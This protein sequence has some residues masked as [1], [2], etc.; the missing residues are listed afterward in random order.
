VLIIP[1]PVWAVGFALEQPLHDATFACSA[2]GISKQLKYKRLLCPL[3]HLKTLSKLFYFII[4][5]CFWFIPI[6]I[7]FGVCTFSVWVCIIFGTND[8]EL[9]SRAVLIRQI[10]FRDFQQFSPEMLVRMTN[11]V[12][13][14]FGLDSEERIRFEFSP[15][16]KRI[17]LSCQN[18][19]L[20]LPPLPMDR[21]SQ[22]ERNLRIIAKARYNQWIK[23]E[24]NANTKEREKI[25]K[26]ILLEL[27]YWDGVYRE[28]L[29]AIGL[30]QPTIQET[31]I[32]TDYLVNEFKEG[33]S[34]EQIAQIENF[35]RKIIGAF[36]QHE[37]KKTIDKATN[38]LELFFKPTPQIK[39]NNTKKKIKEGMLYRGGV[40]WRL[41]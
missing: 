33:E 15:I 13:L 8:P 41:I 24:A 36:A 40:T 22:C 17:I 20:K 6:S 3:C 25:M 38:T 30:P 34:T 16:E 18:Q 37:I 23:A 21:I 35:K 2:L 7:V 39:K 29:T 11:R 12:E 5:F 27:D 19:S 4:N 31:L 9:V 14:E 10:Q 32:Q 26:R 1:K 28:F